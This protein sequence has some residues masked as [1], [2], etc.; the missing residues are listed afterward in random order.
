MV[1]KILVWIGPECIVI[2]VAAVAVRL[3][4]EIQINHRLLVL[5]ANVLQ[6]PEQQRVRI[7]GIERADGCVEIRK[8]RDRDDN[9]GDYICSAQDLP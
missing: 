6:A 5:R 8:Y 3:K 7:K 2:V 9:Y 4:V 1:I